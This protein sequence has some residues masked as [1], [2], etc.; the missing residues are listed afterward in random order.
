M[1]VGSPL[2]EIFGERA[3]IC[4]GVLPRRAQIFE[5]PS[6]SI[7][8]IKTRFVITNVFKYIEVADTGETML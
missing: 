8:Q 1:G 3:N 6:I 5:Q 4:E 2:T 7:E